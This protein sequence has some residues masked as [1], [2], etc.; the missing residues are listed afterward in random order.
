MSSEYRSPACVPDGALDLSPGD[1][2]FPWPPWLR[3]FAHRP[4]PGVRPGVGGVRRRSTRH[5]PLRGRRSRRAACSAVLP[6]SP[7][8]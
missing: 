6:W 2:R 5:P 7:A 8:L 1:G 4:P 3:V